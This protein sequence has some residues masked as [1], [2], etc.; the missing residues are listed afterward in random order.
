[1]ASK[2]V[3]DLLVLAGVNGN[4]AT[5]IENAVLRPVTDLSGNL[6]GIVNPKDGK[7]KIYPKYLRPKIA[8]IGNSIN[9]LNQVDDTLPAWQARG[10]MTWLQALSGLAFDRVRSNKF[11]WGAQ[12]NAGG[13]E[14]LDRFGNYAWGGANLTLGSTYS[15]LNHIPQAL[16]KFIDIPD[17]VYLTNI[18]ENDISSGVAYATLVTNITILIECV[19]QAFPNAFIIIATPNPSTSYTT[20]AHH[21]VFTQISGWIAGLS[22]T[23]PMVVAEIN[24]STILAGTTDQPVPSYTF[25]NI[26][27]PNERGA[28]VRAKSALAQLN[29]LFPN[30]YDVTKLPY[31]A[32][33]LAQA[34]QTNPDFSKKGAPAGAIGGVSY[35]SYDWYTDTNISPV[36]VDNSANNAGINLTLGASATLGSTGLGVSPTSDASAVVLSGNN[37]YSQYMAVSKVRIVNPAN[38][39]AITLAL[40]F[41]GGTAI[42]AY[43]NNFYGGGGNL[44]STYTQGLSDIFQAGDT[45]TLSTPPTAP[46]NTNTT[47]SYTQTKV[48]ATNGLTPT[49]TSAQKPSVDIIAQNVIQVSGV[50]PQAVLMASAGTYTNNTQGTQQV[51]IVGGTASALTITRGGVVVS[52]P[53][54]NVVVLLSSG[55]ILTTTYTVTPIFT[56][57]QIT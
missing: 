52:L 12:G 42:T 1:M 41:S 10:H 32:T 34:F 5:E 43:G 23:N 30:P 2:D 28:L 55:D 48:T 53:A 15:M 46:Q 3:S 38:L 20:T 11:D 13:A 35:T 51:S 44:A 57:L 40:N 47:I 26:I 56:V 25:D 39:F 4:I 24:T 31:S 50:Q 7:T 49:S 45:L 22:A 9:G 54:T 6:T 16:Q 36:V 18:V 33:T 37:L 14:T 21:T 19:Q 27:H 17:I 29:Y 8:T